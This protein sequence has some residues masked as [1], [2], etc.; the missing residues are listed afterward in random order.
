[1]IENYQ[2]RKALEHITGS[3]TGTI[4]VV[5]GIYEDGISLVLPGEIIPGGKHYPYNASCTFELG[6][7][8]HIARENGTIIVEYP[9]AGGVSM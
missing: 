7:R 6:Q 9:I 2:Q 4:A 1:M 5:G 8:V 3:S